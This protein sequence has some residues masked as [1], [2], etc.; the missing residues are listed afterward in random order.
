MLRE[1]VDLIYSLI[2]QP[3][4][5]W[6]ELAEKKDTDSEQFLNRY[7][8]PVFGIM[9]LFAFIGVVTHKKEFDVQVALKTTISLVVSVFLGFYL[10]SFALTEALN[11]VF[12]KIKQPKIHQQFVGYASSLIY[13]VNMLLA[14]FPELVFLKFLI[15][16]TVYMVW[17]GATP[18]L[19]IEEDIKTKF[20]VI[21]GA[22]ILIIPTLVESLIVVSMPGLRN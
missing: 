18:Y 10:A 21:A 16:Y 1:I 20:T 15:L 4:K 6:S 11:S 22:I 9:A 5:S 12:G 19:D 13:V 8:Y 2:L 3:A 7:L 14:L 17:E